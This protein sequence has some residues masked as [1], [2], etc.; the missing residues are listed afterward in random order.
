M[1]ALPA[2]RKHVRLQSPL[3]PFALILDL[4]S[5]ECCTPFHERAMKAAFHGAF[6]SRT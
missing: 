3:E 1:P 6:I 4:V 5:G 2:W